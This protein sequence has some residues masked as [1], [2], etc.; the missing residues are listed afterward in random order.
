MLMRSFNSLVFGILFLLASCLNLV[1]QSDAFFTKLGDKVPYFDFVTINDD[2]H[3]ITDYH[4]KNLLI[5]LFG[6]RCGPC[7]EELK[8]IHK[9]LSQYTTSDIFE[10]LIIGATDTKEQLEKF[11]NKKNYGFT[12]VPDSEQNIFNKF[13][14]HTIPR[15]VMLDKQGKIVYQSKGFN[16]SSFDKLIKFVYRQLNEGP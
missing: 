16:Y 4:G 7:L 11:E 5:V 3:T 1:A 14:E 2:N 9:T 10:I 8:L 12:Y 13:A 6:T 15:C